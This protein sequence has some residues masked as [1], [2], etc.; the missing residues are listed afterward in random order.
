[1]VTGYFGAATQAAVRNFQQSQGLPMTGAV[2]AA[3]AAAI[4]RVSCGS[5]PINYSNYSNGYNY[6]NVI[7][8]TYNNNYPYNNNYTGTLALISLSQ[9]TGAPGTVVTV[10]G[11]GFDPV[12]NTLTFGTQ[13]IAGIPSVNGTSLTF[14]V[15]SYG[16]S[17]NSNQTVQFSITDSHGTS[18]SIQWGTAETTSMGEADGLAES[19]SFTSSITAVG[20]TGFL[21]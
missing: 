18:N 5:N 7:P 14:T 3:T 16:Y 1:M 2:D 8:Y 9:N 10:S 6:N 11:T 4:N 15:P 21:K 19:A 20:S 17:Y 12:N 13:T